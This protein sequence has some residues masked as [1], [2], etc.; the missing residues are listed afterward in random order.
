MFANIKICCNFVGVII[1]PATMNMS[2]NNQ[3]QN[4]Q[5]QQ[6]NLNNNQVRLSLFLH[7]HRSGC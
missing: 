6:Q 2:I 3:Q 4:Q 1:I 5:N 7:F